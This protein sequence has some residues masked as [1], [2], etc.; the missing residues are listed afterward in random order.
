MMENPQAGVIDIILNGSS[1]VKNDFVFDAGL[2]ALLALVG[3]TR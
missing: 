3:G 2:L 1:L